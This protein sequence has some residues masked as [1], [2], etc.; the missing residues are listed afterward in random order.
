MG[1]GTKLAPFLRESGFIS[2][3]DNFIRFGVGLGRKE[4]EPYI[5]LGPSAPNF[6]RSNKAVSTII[7]FHR[8][9][10]NSDDG[11]CVCV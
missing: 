1:G 8:L 4:G 11:Q 9:R 3:L 6:L 7:G 2:A 10:L 5:Y